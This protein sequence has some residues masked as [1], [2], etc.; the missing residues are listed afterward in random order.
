ML[1]Q[2]TEV[3]LKDHESVGLVPAGGRE[4]W[5]TQG[6]EIPAGKA[7]GNEPCWGGLRLFEHTNL[8]N[9]RLHELTRGTCFLCLP[10]LK[11][12]C[13][14]NGIYYSVQESIYLSY[15]QSFI[16]FR[17]SVNLSLV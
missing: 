13:G 16:A 10:V 9:T 8:Q 6:R 1:F 14:M 2:L 17:S 7:P 5:E 4:R 11:L 15:A 12:Q 3:T